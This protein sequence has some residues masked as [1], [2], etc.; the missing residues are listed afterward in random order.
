M[1]LTH[2]QHLLDSFCLMNHLADALL[3]AGTTDDENYA[4]QTIVEQGWRKYAL[5]CSTS[6]FILSSRFDKMLFRT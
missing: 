5:G 1:S 4:V 6:W 2:A 3:Y